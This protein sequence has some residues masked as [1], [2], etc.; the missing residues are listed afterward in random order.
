MVKIISIA[1]LVCL[2]AVPAAQAAPSRTQTGTFPRPAPTGCLTGRNRAFP[3]PAPSPKA[4]LQTISQVTMPHG[5]IPIRMQN[6]RYYRSNDIWVSLGPVVLGSIISSANRAPQ[7]SPVTGTGRGSG[8]YSYSGS[9]DREYDISLIRSVQVRQRLRQA[10]RE[11]GIG[12]GPLGQP[13]LA[14]SW[15]GEGRKTALDI[16]RAAGP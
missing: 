2:S 3:G 5:V 11:D 13:L 9:Y 15:E 1:L 12:Y 6:Y 4:D 7:Y 8:S 10:G 16:C 14:K